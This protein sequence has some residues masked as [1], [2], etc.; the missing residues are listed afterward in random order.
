[1][2]H[3]SHSQVGMWFRCQ[4]QWWFRYIQKEKIPPPGP[5]YFGIKFDDAATTY[6]YMPKIKTHK[7]LPI[8]QVQDHF[9]AEFDAGKDD[10]DWGAKSADLYREAGPVLIKQ[11]LTEI[12]PAI[13]PI[14]VQERVEIRP[15]GWD[16]TIITITDI[17]TKSEV[18]D[19][20]T[21]GKSPSKDKETGLHLLSPDHTQQAIMYN[22]AFRAQHKRDPVT[23]RNI[24]HV[25]KKAPEIVQVE[26]IVTP[27]HEAFTLSVFKMVRDQIEA[28]KTSGIFLPNRS[29]MM[30]SQK[31]CG[32]WN[33]CHAKFGPTICQKDK[34]V[35]EAVA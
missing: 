28:S 13:Q 26:M 19:V 20:K 7:D 15:K 10:A 33:L 21:C 14:S 2:N 34:K 11:H 27:E 12:S 16:S 3:I 8:P 29:H 35:A 25:V 30:C 1:M 18:L 6:N 9:V 31:Q 22:L 17:A 4:A 23:H 24:Y 5:M 32:Y